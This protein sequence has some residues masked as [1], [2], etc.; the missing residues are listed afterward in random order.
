MARKITYSK[1]DFASLRQEQ[2]DYLKKYYP[3]VIQDFSD[4]SI[5]SVFID[6]NAA[7]GDNLH[8]HIDRSLHETVLDYAQEK[9]SIYNIAKTYGLKLPTRS[10]ALAVVEIS[11][12]VPVLGDAEDNRYLP[13]LRAGSKFSGGGNRF[14]LLDDIDFSSPIN[15]QGAVDRVK[16]PNYL[17]G[18][19]TSY[20]VT[21][22]GL[23]VN[24]STK[25]YSHKFTTQPEAF[26]KITLPENNVISIDSVIAKDGV[27]FTNNPTYAEFLDS[28]LKWYEVDSLAKNRVF[29]INTTRGVDPSTG[30]YYGEYDEVDNRFIKE[31]TPEGYCVLTYGS[32][33]DDSTDILDDFIQSAGDINLTSFLENKSLGNAPRKNTT[34]YVKYRVGGGIQGNVGV[35]VIDTVIE[36]ITVTNGPDA[37]TRKTV[38]DSFTVR[39]VTP[40]VGG[41]DLPTVDE[42]KHLVGYNFASQ[43]RAVTLEDYKA[44]IRQMPTKFGSPAKVGVK[45]VQNK[46]EVNLI[47]YDALGNYSNLVPSVLMNNVA[48]FLSEYR[49][50]ND[51]VEVKPAKVIDLG[52]E[53]T[54]QVTPENQT[55]VVAEVISKINTKFK[56]VSRDLGEQLY[57]ADIQKVITNTTGVLGVTSLSVNNKVGGDYSANEIRQSYTDTTKKTI[58]TSEG[59]VY[60]DQSEILQIR[61]PEKDIVVRA[62]V[63]QPRRK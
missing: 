48:E 47:T 53:T 60:V 27:S 61:F 22:K 34:M 42:V 4:A 43:E 30:I 17:D 35:G 19:I 15:V 41:A 10:A 11:I 52:I 26:Y 51:Y 38:T 55:E 25:I 31:F 16:V 57:L 46:I 12:E 40:S 2:I 50:I 5:M 14:E 58:D 37:A 63:L 23:V 39:N 32:S 8:Y 21:K 54:I 62:Q 49:M 1:R 3:D 33:T 7:I 20:T 56:E 36:A 18:R 29:T 45:Q 59:I 9:Q 6:L 44:R 28:D 13:I 24:G